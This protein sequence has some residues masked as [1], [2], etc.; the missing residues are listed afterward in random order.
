M[1]VRL[2]DWLYYKVGLIGIIFDDLNI[3]VFDHVCNNM[4]QFSF[5]QWWSEKYMH[6]FRY[7]SL[8][9]Y[10]H[11]ANMMLL[12]KIWHSLEYTSSLKNY[13]G[14]AII[15]SGHFPQLRIIF[16]RFISDSMV[17]YLLIMKCPVTRMLRMLCTLDSVTTITIVLNKHLKETE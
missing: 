6:L 8:N 12:I 4:F 1:I 11:L 10:I 13:L 2:C 16:Q 3:F 15:Q 5:T 17:T 7:M 9:E 14:I